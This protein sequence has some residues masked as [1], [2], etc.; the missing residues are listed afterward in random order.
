MARGPGRVSPGASR[1]GTRLKREVLVYPQEYAGMSS[2]WGPLRKCRL[3]GFGLIL[4]AGPI[5]KGAPWLDRLGTGC[6]EPL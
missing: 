1:G 5:L 2:G 6:M 4:W 3:V